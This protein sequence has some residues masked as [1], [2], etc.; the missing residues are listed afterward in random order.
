MIERE[1]IREVNDSEIGGRNTKERERERER[2][3]KHVYI[4]VSLRV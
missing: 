1:R 2:E 4:S 3:R